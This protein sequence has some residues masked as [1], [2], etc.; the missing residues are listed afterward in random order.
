[1]TGLDGHPQQIVAVES[2]CHW[3][4]TIQYQHVS[5]PAAAAALE[6][7]QRA[8]PGSEPPIA[9]ADTVLRLHPS[10]VAVGPAGCHPFRRRRSGSDG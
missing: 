3:R 4:L 9:V 1:M 6:D 2:G 5:P 7:H 8:A 10:P